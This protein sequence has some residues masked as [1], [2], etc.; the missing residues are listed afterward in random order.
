MCLLVVPVTK[1][2]D[3]SNHGKFKVHGFYYFLSCALTANNYDKKRW[4]GRPNGRF[5]SPEH[6]QKTCTCSLK[7]FGSFKKVVRHNLDSSKLEKLNYQQIIYY[8]A[9][10][11]QTCKLMGKRSN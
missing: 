2:I 10:Q 11:R 7:D 5:F 9:V 4:N 1:K 3:L 6:M 8:D